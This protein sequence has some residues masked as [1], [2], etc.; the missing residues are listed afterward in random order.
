[1]PVL[2]AVDAGGTSTRS[3][4]VTADG[5]CLGY[6]RTGSGNPTAAGPDHAAASVA[7][8]AAVAI[9]AAG[10]P[11]EKIGGIVFAM[12]GASPQIDI[13]AFI[14]PLT[15]RGIT[16]TPVFESDLL[17]TFFSGTYRDAGYALVAGTGAAAVR[18]ER[19]SIVATAD[20]FGWLLGDDGSGFYIG[21]RVIRAAMADLDSR[22]PATAL[23]G[24]VLA[25]LGQEGGR[26]PGPD[27][28]PAAVSYALNAL[29]TIR[30]VQL[31]R[32]ARLAFEAPGDNVADSIIRDAADALVHTLNAV[33]TPGAS[34][35]IVLGGGTL[36]R[37]RTLVDRI[38]AGYARDGLSPEIR[39]V[40][41]GV[42]GAAVLA[43]REAGA[44]VDK[45]IFDRLTTSLATVR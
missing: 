13:G 44:T 11:G 26:A 14:A 45:V 3:V 19:G 37:H 23:T 21:H 8:S 38:A 1:M 33:V 36:T 43:L 25:E 27:G 20:G 34:G 15:A 35:P 31:A 16:A 10:V 24:M 7:A 30:P 2:L 9:A 22:G 28:R 4:V 40:A 29:Y 32:F 6:A 17:A 5:R 12:A 41:D 39:T 42:V 18:V